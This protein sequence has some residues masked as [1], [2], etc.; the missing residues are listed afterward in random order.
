[1]YVCMYLCIYVFMYLCMY[2]C[3]YVCMGQLHQICTM[4]LPQRPILDFLK[5]AIFHSNL[6]K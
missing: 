6:L 1:M 2:V 3:M 5:H 4:S